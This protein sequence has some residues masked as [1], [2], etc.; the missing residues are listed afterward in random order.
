MICAIC[1]ADRWGDVADVYC[2]WF[3]VGCG[4]VA[5]MLW[6][7]AIIVAGGVNPYIDQIQFYMDG[8][9][10]YKM[11]HPELSQPVKSPEVVANS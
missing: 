4:G 2:V 5:L 1:F 6:I 3:C 10:T 11:L 7:A 8:T 9:K